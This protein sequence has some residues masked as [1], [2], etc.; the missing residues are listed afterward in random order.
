MYANFSAGKLISV[1]V[2]VLFL[3][4]CATYKSK[5]LDFSSPLHSRLSAL[6][7]QLK[8]GNPNERSRYRV[9]PEDGIDLTEIG[10]LA[11]LNNPDL[12]AQRSLWSLANAEVLS[13]RLLPDPQF[14]AGLDTPTGN[15][16]GLVN[17]WSLGL[18][19]DIVPLI[20]RKA[21]IKAARKHQD[22]VYLDL[23]WQE[24]QVIQ[25]ART[26]AV[27][28]QL[29]AKQLSLLSEARQLYLDRY[30]RSAQALK[31][32]NVTLDV[33]GTDLTALIDNLSQLNQLEQTHIQTRH[34]LNLL[35]GL[36]PKVE[37]PLAS[38]PQTV[39]INTS[40]V[41]N[42][43][44]N[45]AKNRPDLMALKAGYD[46][47][48]SRVRAAILSQFP[49][50]GLGVNRA[51][52][53]GNLTTVGVSLSLNLPFFS[54][55][56]GTIA[57]ERATRE[58]LREEFSARLAKT[59]IDTDR[60]LSLQRALRGQQERLQTYLPHLESLVER[61]RRA[62]SHGDIDALTFLNMESTWINKRLE[63]I[64]I[65]QAAWENR[66]ALEALLAL[67]GF[68]GD[69]LTHTSNQLEN[70]P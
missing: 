37:L 29:E 57:V 46:S 27:R 15:T 52:D 1:C 47:Q 20:T 41:D 23:L 48:E 59:E 2:A 36:A 10:I 14:S 31:D 22:Q 45:L 40:V 34:D 5:P 63:Q 62:Y 65:T 17:P 6:E 28:Q 8:S 4:G 67:P 24:W 53:A 33:S 13:A 58:Q 60:L 70:K 44:K 9:V 55:N 3:G 39:P 7:L 66:I 54:G 68:P 30:Q 49:S 51:R 69:S 64:G 43:L 32:G 35:L 42:Q 50:L 11:V 16:A 25:Q 56:R 26:L 38:L 18:G 12:K 61:A 21:R 19:Y